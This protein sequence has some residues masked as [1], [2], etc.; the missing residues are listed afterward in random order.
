MH[1]AAGSKFLSRRTMV[2][3]SLGIVSEIA[4]REGAI[5][6][7]RLVDDRDVRRDLLVLDEP[8]QHRRRSVGGIRNEPLRLETKAL[9]GSLQHGPRRA[10][11]GLAHGAW[12]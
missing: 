6:S 8:V 2:G 1:G 7:R 5:L 9:L 12:G 4:A 10:D 11:L 3:V